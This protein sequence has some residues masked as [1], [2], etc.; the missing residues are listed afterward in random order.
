MAKSAKHSHDHDHAHDHADHDE[1]EV[2]DELITIRDFVRFAVSRFTEAKLA[3]GHGSVDAFDEAVY[4]VLHTL[5][6]PLDRL[7][8]FLDASLTGD[9]RAAIMCVL[10]RRVDERIPAAY[11]TNEAWLGAHKFYV[12]ARVLVPRSFIAELLR[13]ELSPWVADA[14]KVTRVLDLCAGSGCLAILAALTFPNAKVDA[15][16]LSA[17]ALKVA[18]RNVDD[19]GLQAR[20]TL[21]ESD[22]F[23]ALKGKKYDVIV[24]NPPYVTT[25]S[26]KELP[27][28]YQREPALAL[29]SGKDG[30]DHTRKILRD[31]ATYLNKNGVLVAEVGFNREGVE[32]AFPTLPLTWVETSAGDGVVFLATREDL[33]AA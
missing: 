32:A 20:V 24:T 25:A 15:V 30:L 2:P 14:S 4:L 18:K 16:D 7:E 19:Y 1:H 10:T 22:L 28:E 5:H 13:E 8:P 23:A 6:L 3:F 21:I 12:D 17:D 9:E 33:K 26:M 31:A 11:I 29:A 27:T